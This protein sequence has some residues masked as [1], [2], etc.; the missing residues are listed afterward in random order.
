MTSRCVFA[1]AFALFAEIAHSEIVVEG[2]ADCGLWDKA[3]QEKRSAVLEH[4]VLGFLNGMAMGT[5]TEFWRPP[6]ALPISRD[7][8]FLWMDGYCRKEP[9]SQIITGAHRLFRERSG[10]KP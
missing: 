1:I 8:V 9:L 4:Y 6:N 2:Q 5:D 7:A 10:W 3:R